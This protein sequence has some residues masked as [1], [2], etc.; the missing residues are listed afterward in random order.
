M[1]IY[2]AYVSTGFHPGPIPNVV[3][4]ECSVG[5]ILTKARD[6]WLPAKMVG[7]KY[8]RRIAIVNVGTGTTHYDLG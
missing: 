3:H 8:M 7:G 2:P 1:R 6:G 5:A 4:H